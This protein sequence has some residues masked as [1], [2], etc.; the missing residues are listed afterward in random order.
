MYATAVS[1]VERS[2]QVVDLIPKSSEANG[3]QPAKA[4]AAT[5]AATEGQRGCLGRAS[6]GPLAKSKTPGPTVRPSVQGVKRRA[7]ERLVAARTQIKM[8]LPS[9]T[10]TLPRATKCAS[11][12]A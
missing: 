7:G 6:P 4:S 1:D 5:L 10:A 9:H 2:V 3:R 8:N 12:G 11:S